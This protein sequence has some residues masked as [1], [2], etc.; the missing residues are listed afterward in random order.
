MKNVI[1]TTIDT[2]ADGRRV[3]VKNTWMLCQTR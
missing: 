2:V 1:I 3:P